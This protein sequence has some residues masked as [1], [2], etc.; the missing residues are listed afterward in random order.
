[1]TET[2]AE[3]ATVHT[4]PTRTR[5]DR[6]TGRGAGY[7]PARDLG[8]DTGPRT[9]PGGHPEHG[10]AAAPADDDGGPLPGGRTDAV[11]FVVRDAE[12]AARR[13]LD[14][15]GLSCTAYAGPDTGEPETVSY[16]LQ[17]P[18][19]RFVL[20]SVV[21]V[22]GER[23]RTLAAHLATHGEGVVD[24]SVAV[25]DVHYAYDFAVDRGAR[26]YAE[27]YEARDRHGTV[28]LAVIGAPGG[29]RHTLVD[30]S[31]YA[32]PYLPGFVAPTTGPTVRTATGGTG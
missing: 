5:T 11:V 32:G 10:P 29:I 6:G 15:L 17:G 22:I 19:S 4:F 24:L 13:Y 27:P 9:R 18:G 3:Q 16:V 26:S 25:P 30:R 2:A 23:G 8:P 7:D 12:R 14:L 20:T 21:Q 1:M 31:R 28:L